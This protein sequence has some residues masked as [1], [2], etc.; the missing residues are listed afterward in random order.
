MFGFS[1]QRAGNI[2]SI[3]K[4]DLEKS[5]CDLVNSMNKLS[6]FNIQMEIAK[7]KLDKQEA[8]I[9]QLK[10]KLR[11]ALSMKAELKA[12]LDQPNCCGGEPTT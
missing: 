12:E 10:E 4:R 1:F 7:Q 9:N 3:L 2:F 8:E 6:A 5:G 11:E